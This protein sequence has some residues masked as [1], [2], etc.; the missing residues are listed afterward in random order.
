LPAFCLA[1]LNITTGLPTD[2]PNTVNVPVF[3]ERE[4]DVGSVYLAKKWS[5]GYITFWNQKQI[6]GQDEYL[7]FNFDKMK[8]LIFS[9]DQY[10]KQSSYPVDSVSSFEIVENGTIYS[11]EKVPWISKDYYLMPILKSEKGYALYKRLFCKYLRSSYT[12]AGYYSE[13]AKY[14][15][16]ADYYE[17]YLVY[18]GKTTYK[19]LVI[20]EKAVR[21]ALKNEEGLLEEYFK[22]NE[23]D[24]NEQSVLGMIQYIDDKKY[25][26]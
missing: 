19:K 1:Q 18:P 14:D 16:Y 10:G 4:K 26:E 22:L 25:P 15:E 3:T 7:L 11:F 23:P 21:R 20:K 8:N 9:M 17:Y 24:F 2:R 6:P 13:G 5:R 12:N